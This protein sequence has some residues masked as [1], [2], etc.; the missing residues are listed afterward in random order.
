[1]YDLRNT[2]EPST[3]RP[4]FPELPKRRVREDELEEDIMPAAGL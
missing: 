1:M 2:E 3:E 4:E